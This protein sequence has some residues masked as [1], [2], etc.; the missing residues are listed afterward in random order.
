MKYSVSVSRIEEKKFVR[1]VALNN[2]DTLVFSK[3]VTQ[4]PFYT[5][6]EYF[7][8][9]KLILYAIEEGR[10]QK[11]EMPLWFESIEEREK[12]YNS[13]LSTLKGRYLS[14]HDFE[15]LVCEQE[16]PQVIKKLNEAQKDLKTK[17]F[18]LEYHDQSTQDISDA[19]RDEISKM[20]EVLKEHFFGTG[21]IIKHINVKN[22]DQQYVLSRSQ[23]ENE[24]KNINK[25]MLRYIAGL[26]DG[27]IKVDSA[28]MV[29]TNTI[30]VV[31]KNGRWWNIEKDIVISPKIAQKNEVLFRIYHGLGIAA[32]TMPKQSNISRT[33]NGSSFTLN[34]ESVQALRENDVLASIEF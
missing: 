15:T 8:F 31:F 26:K 13:A 27:G 6:G 12:Y 1:E 20:I 21:P 5:S 19:F 33:V 17:I 10:R 32:K 3:I 25:R 16:I 34:H 30:R 18:L 4:K 28:F 7:S 11:I 2:G 22:E 24:L 29:G 23:I 9:D 14:S